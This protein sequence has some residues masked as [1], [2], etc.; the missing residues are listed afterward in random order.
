MKWY[1]GVGVL[2]VF[3]LA[4]Q[5]GWL[6][7][8]TYVLLGLLLVSRFL[9]RTWMGKLSAK[10]KC[11]RTA[12]QIGDVLSVSLTVQNGSHLPVPW[13][14]MEDLMPR[15]ALTQ[16][17]PRLKIKGKRIKVSMIGGKSET[18]LKY[19]VELQQRGYY[20][21]GPLVLESGDLFGLHRRYHVGT[22]PHYVLVYPR[23]LPLSEYELASRRPIGE[24]KLTHRLFEDPTRIAGVRLYQPGDPLNRVHW[25]ATARTR[26]LQSKVYEPSTIAGATILLDFHVGSYHQRGEP[27]R[28]ELAVM[29]AA[30]LGNALYEMGQQVGLIT[31][32]R[33]AADRIREEG[34][35]AD[36]R[37]RQ[38]AQSSAAMVE[39]SDRLQP[40]IVSTR[41]GPEQLMRMLETLA[42]AELTDG[43]T[44]AE[45][46]AETSSRMPRD[47]TVL[48]I[49]G[50]VPPETAMALGNLK[51]QGYAVAAL[52][53]TFSEQAYE[54]AF[55][56]LAA[57][58]VHVRHVPDEASLA[59]MCREQA[60]R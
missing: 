49:L 38:A 36:H 4:F 26:Q 16:R 33:D 8:A 60:V 28:S 27:Y 15:H 22:E 57:E 41:R 7:Y 25:R 3:A 32:G 6:V 19:E 23:V 30:S 59:A 12:A 13:V 2:L 52:L 29:A 35:D 5:L 51:R 42:R 39:T 50:D 47:A 44:L 55:G 24:I 58:G 11:N 20:Q 34:W 46:I 37:T 40:L 18:K 56:R 9:A 48:A 10:R 1:V 17:P 54:K 53:I 14:L 43:M 45:L 31:N 21:I